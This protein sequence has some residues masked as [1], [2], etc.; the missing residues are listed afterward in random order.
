[1]NI[2]QIYW[3][4]CVMLKQSLIGNLSF[5]YEMLQIHSYFT[6]SLQSGCPSSKDFL[7]LESS[8]GWLFFVIYVVSQI[9]AFFVRHSPLPSFNKSLP[10]PAH[11]LSYVFISFPSWNWKLYEIILTFTYFLCFPSLE[12]KLIKDGDLVLCFHHCIPRA[13]VYAWQMAH[14]SCSLIFNDWT[15]EW[16]NK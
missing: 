11:S 13:K 4:R 6:H 12:F 16:M 10:C 8:R 3:P 5:T 1:M 15:N 9:I 2:H 14:I 7:C